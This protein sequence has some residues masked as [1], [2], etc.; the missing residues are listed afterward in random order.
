MYLYNKIVSFSDLK[1]LVSKLTLYKS[2]A[3]FSIYCLSLS[4]VFKPS[5]KKLE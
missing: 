5:W 4:A 3:N 1:P 2:A